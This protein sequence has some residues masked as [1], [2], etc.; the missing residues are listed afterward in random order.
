MRRTVTT[1]LALGLAALGLTLPG[2]SAQAATVC[3]DLYNEY[4]DKG[5]NRVHAWSEPNCG[6]YLLGDNVVG[7]YDYNW[8]NEAGGFRGDDNDNAESVMN[9]AAASSIVAFYRLSGDPD[10]TFADG[11][12]C[13]KGSE[14]YVDSLARNTFENARDLSVTNRISS[15][16][17]VTPSA[18]TGYSYIS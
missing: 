6:G 8:G 16:Q 14:L 1:S 7:G 18:C 11:Y 13:L 10:D 12:V 15:H 9:T 3:D 5:Y 4:Q 2:T 17:W